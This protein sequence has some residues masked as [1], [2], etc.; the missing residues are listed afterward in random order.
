MQNLLYRN[1]DCVVLICRDVSQIR[2]ISKLASDNKMLQVYNSS[3]THE[4]ITPL[5]ALIEIAS[6]VRLQH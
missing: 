1:D 3:V 4:L 6:N 5:R 2:K